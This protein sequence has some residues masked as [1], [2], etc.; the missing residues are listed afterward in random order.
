[1]N[2]GACLGREQASQPASLDADE[3][4]LE[5]HRAR[6]MQIVRRRLDSRLRSR[7]DAS[8]IVQETFAVA[9]RDRDSYQCQAGVPFFAWL[10]RLAFRQIL[11]AS[12]RHIA[13]EKRTVLREHRVE[14]ANAQRDLAEAF[15]A[16]SAPSDKLVDKELSER[17]SVAL[18]QLSRADREVVVLRYLQSLSTDEVAEIIGIS[19]SAARKRLTRALERLARAL[20]SEDSSSDSI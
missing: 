3:E 13:A 19:P 15:G 12:E 7:L 6:L 2:D 11:R 20:H 9:I 10:R 18:K 16:A 4:M 8:D 5:Q 17:T 1:M 14:S